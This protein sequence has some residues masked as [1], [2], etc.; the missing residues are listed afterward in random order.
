M[1]LP[2]SIWEPKAL[3]WRCLK[4]NDSMKNKTKT[5][6]TQRE[7]CIPK[8]KPDTQTVEMAPEKVTSFRFERDKV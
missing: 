8:I 1:L 4:Q 3:D 6:K 5:E 7:K 2:F